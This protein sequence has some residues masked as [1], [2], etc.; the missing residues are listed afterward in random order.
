MRVGV[1][2]RSV[3]GFYPWVAGM[4]PGGW[5][6]AVEAWAT[7]RDM[8]AEL[9]AG[10]GADRDWPVVAL[11]SNSSRTLWGSEAVWGMFLMRGEF[12]LHTFRSGPEFVADIRCQQREGWWTDLHKARVHHDEPPD[13]IYLG[14]AYVVPGVGNLMGL[15]W[16]TDAE[17]YGVRR[18][19]RM[20]LWLPT[21]I[22]GGGDGYLAYTWWKDRRRGGGGGGGFARVRVSCAGADE[23]SG[24]AGEVSGVRDADKGRGEGGGVTRVLEYSSAGRVGQFGY[25]R[26][27]L[28]A[29]QVLSI[30]A[31][32][33][34][35]VIGGFGTLAA[36]RIV[37][38][39]SRPLLEDWIGFVLWCVDA[40][41][42]HRDPGSVGV[43][44]WVVPKASWLRRYPRGLSGGAIMPMGV[45]GGSDDGRGDDLWA[46]QG[47]RTR[48]V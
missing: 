40:V 7:A 11:A 42:V 23:E 21:G 3:G 32:P 45:G 35:L 12:S 15:G 18:A 43:L 19:Y 1:V 25:A 38:G 29:W 41:R 36:V 39:W 14:P 17:W 48:Q 46:W 33:L 9:G 10:L 20:P 24:A 30:L 16:E 31:A 4:V 26:S 44:L 6:D 27:L 13:H 2:G 22:C 47:V 5:W 28:L 8:R 34:G 37:G